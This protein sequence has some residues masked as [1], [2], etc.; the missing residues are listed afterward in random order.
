MPKAR[1]PAR[2]PELACQ[3]QLDTPQLEE[4]PTTIKI[5]LSLRQHW[6]SKPETGNKRDSSDYRSANQRFGMP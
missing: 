1:I 5:P 2:K 3:N 6:V 4:L